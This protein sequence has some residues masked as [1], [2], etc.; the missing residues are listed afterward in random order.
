MKKKIEKNRFPEMNRE[1]QLLVTDIDGTLLDDNNQVTPKTLE[2]FQQIKRQDIKIALATGR[3][4]PDA[5]HFAKRIAFHCPM[6]LIHGAV[7][8]A[9]EG[10]IINQQILPI[11]SIPVLLELAQKEEIPYQIFQNDRFIMPRKT[12]W[13]DIYL[14]YSEI[15]PLIMPDIVQYLK[16]HQDIFAFTFL[17]APER[18]G[19]MRKKIEE[20]LNGSVSIASA[21]PNV[22][23]VLAPGVNKGKAIKELASYLDIPLSK[24]IAIGDNYNDIEMIKM[25][26]LGIAMGNAPQKVKDAATYITMDNNH[27]GIAHFIST[28]LSHQSD[29]Q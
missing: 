21:H 15:E 24:V 29:R 7:I 28:L 9:F 10:S 16:R 23:E 19:S 8:Q 4:F 12:K 25:A 13:N 11:E 27:D 26:G 17:G 22:L 5:H 6:I 18:L 20:K 1:Y 3:F 14:N 2:A